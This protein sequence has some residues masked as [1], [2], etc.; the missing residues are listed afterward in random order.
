MMRVLLCILGDSETLAVLLVLM[1]RVSL[2][3]LGELGKIGG[4][5]SFYVDG[6]DVSYGDFDNMA[7]LN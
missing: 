6:S 1:M 5:V 7:D 4:A 3:V 2:C